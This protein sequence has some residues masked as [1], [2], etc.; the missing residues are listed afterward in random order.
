VTTLEEHVRRA[1]AGDRRALEAVVQGIQHL[2]YRLALRMLG[3]PADAQDASQDI[4]ARVV[5]NLGSYRGDSAFTTWVYRVATNHLLDARRGRAEQIA[6]FDALAAQIDAGAAEDAEASTDTVLKREVVLGCTQAMLLCLDRPHRIALVLGDVF[7]LSHEEAAYVLDVTAATYRKRLERA[8]ELVVSFLRGRCGVFDASARCR[9]SRQ[10][11]YATR[12]GELRPDDLR[13]AQ[14]PVEDG[15][16]ADYQELVDVADVGRMYR[17][18]PRFTAPD[19]ML[20]E[21]RRVIAAGPAR[22]GA[23]SEDIGAGV[24]APDS[25]PPGPSSSARYGRG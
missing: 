1:V 25:R 10:V 20:S 8:R 7:E 9:C 4:L 13:F 21:L 19:V 3:E 14:L 24:G 5:T 17:S 2:V 23:D 15:S 11:A 22:L 12:I 16:R 6:A 18:Q